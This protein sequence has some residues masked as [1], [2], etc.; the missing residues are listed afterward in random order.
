MNWSCFLQNKWLEEG[1]KT[2]K[3]LQVSAQSQPKN[4]IKVCVTCKESS[5]VSQLCLRSILMPD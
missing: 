1:E 4:V 2:I 3:T 5:V